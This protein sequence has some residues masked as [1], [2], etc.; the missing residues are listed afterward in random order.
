[1]LPLQPC[2]RRRPLGVVQSRSVPRRQQADRKIL[3]HD[4]QMLLATTE[5]RHLDP[6]SV[7]A[8]VLPTICTGQGYDQD[9]TRRRSVTLLAGVNRRA[10]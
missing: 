7:A 8:C 2:L 1:M 10:A 5:T 4:S 3:C 6:A 9:T